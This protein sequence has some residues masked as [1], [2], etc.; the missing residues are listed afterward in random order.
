MT[1]ASFA[2][3]TAVATAPTGGRQPGSWWVSAGSGSSEAA[4][5]AVDL[6]SRFTGLPVWHV[7][8]FLGAA[9][10]PI[11]VTREQ[12]WLQT[13]VPIPW[14]DTICRRMVSRLGPTLV[15]DI[16]A[17]PNYA[18][19]PIALRHGI[20]AYAGVPVLAAGDRLLGVL[21]GCD[22]E[23]R[24]PLPEL[25]E[26]MLW[27]VARLLGPLLEAVGER[28]LAALAADRREAQRRAGE[29]LT[30]LPGRRGWGLLLDGEERRGRMNGNAS[31]IAVVDLGFIHSAVEIQRAVRLVDEA[32]TDVVTARLSTRQVGLLLDGLVATRVDAVAA[33]ALTRLAAAG[34]R[35]TAAW[36]S[37]TEAT[38]L[39]GTWALAEKRLFDA[40]RRT[41]ATT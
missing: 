3:T 10:Q 18:Q 30:R 24:G 27:T 13:G 16:A 19:A 33:T 26:Q 32:L 4:R 28:D 20:R 40:R 34:Y 11:A 22:H 7:S 37:R 6:A 9:A 38:S 2:T 25:T 5:D 41:R 31:S 29:T 23:P 14:N 8:R 15:P 36:A 1:T 12:P 17:V 21:A 35:A 39:R